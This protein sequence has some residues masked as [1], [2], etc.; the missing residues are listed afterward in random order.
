MRKV[1][2]AELKETVL[3]GNFCSGCGVCSALNDNGISMKMNELGQYFPEITADNHSRETV[4]PFADHQTDEDRLA[5]TFLPAEK[6]HFHRDIG[7]YSG[8]YAG[9]VANEKLRL[10]G[11]S[12]GGVTW[13]LTQ[14]LKKNLTD[15]VFHI[16]EAT[17]ENIFFSYDKSQSAEEIEKGAKSRYYPVTMEKA[18]QFIR[19]NEGRY[20]IVGLP[21][22]IKAIRLLQKTEPVFRDRIRFTVSLFCGHLKTTHY[23]SMLISQLGV[24]E[25]LVKSID[26]RHKI[27][28]K[29]ASEYGTRLMRKDGKEVI[30]PNKELFGTDWGWGLFKLKACDYCDDII[31]ETADIS[32]GDAWIPGF[33]GDWKGTNIVVIRNPVLQKLWNEAIKSGALVMKSLSPEKLIE[34]QAGGFRHRREGLAYRLYLDRKKGNWTPPKRVKPRKI[35][36][37]KRRKIYKIR[38]LL[39]DKSLYSRNYRDI[40]LFKNEILPL[41]EKLR[42]TYGHSAWT[43]IRNKIKSYFKKS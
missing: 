38:I 39:R 5:K 19:E 9:H 13:M 36:S 29:K 17:H 7:Y 26:Y 42:K 18:L 12:G 8:I 25:N 43:S 28:G 34:S 10:Q 4:C 15:T 23:T 22:F 32:F 33:V 3:K 6:L 27:P 16:K 41:V 30:K 14:L 40:N 2:L 37:K 1:T 24:D 31:G 11:S 20:T 35:S 21:C